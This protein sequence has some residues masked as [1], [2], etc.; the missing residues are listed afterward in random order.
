M[1]FDAHCDTIS[2]ALDNKLSLNDKKLAFNLQDVKLPHIQALATFIDSKYRNGFERANNILDKFYEEYNIHKDEIILIKEKSDIEKSLNKLGILL[3]IENGT[4]IDT[5]IN[6]VE[7]LYNRGIRIM[8]ITWNDDN[9]LGCGALTTNDTGL[10]DLGRE[11]VKKLNELNIL[12]D[13]S[14]SSVN[15]FYDTLKCCIGRPLIATHSCV[16]NLCNHPRNLTDEQIREIANTGGV[17]GICFYSKFLKDTGKANSD[18]IIEHIEYIINLVGEDYVGLG[19][20]FDGMKKK[21]YP[22][23]IKGT[24]NLNIIADKLK[25]IGLNDIQINKIMGK[26]FLR[27]LKKYI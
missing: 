26:N 10:T 11:Y 8:S 17:I 21:F 24:K 13:I 22:T 12:V 15:T 1:T 18:D 19:S 5:D 3:T 14:H 16:K 20:D 4:A 27:V 23:D 9:Q 6:N 2:V 25:K 7:K